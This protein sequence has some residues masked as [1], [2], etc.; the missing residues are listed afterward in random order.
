[1]NS[2][3]KIELNGALITGRIDGIDN[4]V[5]NYRQNDD[6]GT[7][8]KSYSSELTFYD[9]GYQLLYSNLINNPNGFNTE[10][11][12]KIYDECCGN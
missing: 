4:F 1:M 7:V 2:T 5:I 8:V 10:V 12:V 3:L 9:D 6:D 11:T